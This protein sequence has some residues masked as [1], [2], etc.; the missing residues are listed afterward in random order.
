MDGRSD[1]YD[2][3][4]VGCVPKNR[5][6]DVVVTLSRFNGHDL[7]DLRVH[8]LFGG[9][10]TKRPTRKGISLN[11][12]RL[13]DLLAVLHRAGGEAHR[14]GLLAD[15]AGATLAD[16]DPKDQTAAERQRRRRERLRASRDH[17]V[18]NE[19]VTAPSLFSEH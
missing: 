4:V 1:S 14:L 11:V 9:A 10:D 15:A 17:D 7:L 18:T 8:A 12:A 3:V 19:S 6:E 2:G 5:A 13:P 16:T